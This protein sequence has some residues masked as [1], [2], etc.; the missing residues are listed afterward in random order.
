MYSMFLATPLS[1]VGNGVA[2]E[3]S[4]QSK[5]LSGKVVAFL[6]NTFWFWFSKFFKRDKTWQQTPLFNACDANDMPLQIP[7]FTHQQRPLFGVVS[8]CF[9]M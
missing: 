1:A 4:T 6:K 2:T 5:K 7:M 9:V 8:G 3:N